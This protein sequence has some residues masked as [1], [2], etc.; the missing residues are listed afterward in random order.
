VKTPDDYTEWLKRQIEENPQEPPAETWERIAESLDLEG[1]WQGINQDLELDGLWQTIDQRLIQADKV[2]WWHKAG[3]LLTTM[4]VVMLA[5]LPLLHSLDEEKQLAEETAAVQRQLDPSPDKPE[6]SPFPFQAVENIT[7]PYAPATD[8]DS[9]TMY[10]PETQVEAQQAG[11]GNS[12]HA[13]LSKGGASASA[14]ASASSRE[15]SASAQRGMAEPKEP[16][17]RHAGS[18]VRPGTE[19]AAVLP[20]ID[21]Q[22]EATGQGAVGQFGRTA[23]NDEQADADY[24]LVQPAPETIAA[25]ADLD[26][27]A[28]SELAVPPVPLEEEAVITKKS[29]PTAGWRLGIGGAARM[30]YLLNEKTFRGMEKSS[31]TTSLPAFRRSFSLQ[32]ERVLSPRLALLTD[33]VVHH[34]AGQRYEEYYG[35]VY[36]TTDTRLRYSQLNALL[37]FTPQHRAF[38]NR[39]HTRWLAGLSGGWLHEASLSGPLGTTDLSAEYNKHAAGLLL[40]FEYVVPLGGNIRMGYGLRGYMDLFNIYAGTAEIPPHFRVT[41]SASL[42][43]TLSFKYE[44]RK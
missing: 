9:Q 35:G 4:A 14:E 2:F 41:R 40:G 8:S 32:A 13:S 21:S 31:L 10:P 20:V 44:L 6:T 7:A 38:S 30:S 5:M 23:S 17:R 43:F 1:A 28:P 42:D 22:I 19:A 37:A 12:A 34:E 11:T 27:T 18:A 3:S 16:T 15:A 33:L 25:A 24:L 36:G 39:A 26:G 29:L